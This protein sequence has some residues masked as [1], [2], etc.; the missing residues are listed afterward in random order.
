MSSTGSS[1]R[2]SDRSVARNRSTPAPS[3]PRWRRRPGRSEL[4]T[5][6]LR[7]RRGQDIAPTERLAPEEIGRPS[8]CL[9]TTVD[10]H[11]DRLS[12]M[13]ASNTDLGESGVS[14][15]LYSTLSQKIEE[16]QP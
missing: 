4:H 14:L 13:P 10:G 8:C 16:F 15:R 12:T 1:E 6:G 11:A 9:G 5:H 3:G 2:S 7:R